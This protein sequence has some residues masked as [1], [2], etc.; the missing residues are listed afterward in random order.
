[1]STVDS[2]N[3]SRVGEVLLRV[4]DLI[5]EYK[6][7]RSGVV[8][9]VAGVSFEIKSG[10]TVAVVGESGCGKSSLAKGVMQLVETKSGK[11]VLD[12]TEFSSL[13]G[14]EL[15]RARPK[16]QMIFQD[17]VASLDPHLT[18]RALVEQPMKV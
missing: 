1:M 10:E 2:A 7:S 3:K 4:E 12:G 6:G 18:V 16:M 13:K 17:S 8:Q 5:V 15:R 14:E 9:A 11:V